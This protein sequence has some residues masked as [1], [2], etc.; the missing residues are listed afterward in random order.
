M[1]IADI[2]H[3]W[4]PCI[5][6]LNFKPIPLYIALPVLYKGFSMKANIPLVAQELLGQSE[7][8]ILL[9]SL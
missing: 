2:T 3:K 6:T 1:S 5:K 8:V 9:T 4:G 7:R